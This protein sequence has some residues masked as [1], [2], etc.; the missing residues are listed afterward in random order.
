[1]TVGDILLALQASLA[2]QRLLAFETGANRATTP[3]IAVDQR[4]VAIT[5][6]KYLA[7]GYAGKTAPSPTKSCQSNF[8]SL[9]VS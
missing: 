1:M 8:I 3:S 7:L 2:A 4:G 6:S 5:L 9:A